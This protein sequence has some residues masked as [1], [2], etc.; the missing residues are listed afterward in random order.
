[1]PLTVVYAMQEPPSSWSQAIFLA[2][3][4]PRAPETPSWRPE[5]LRLLEEMGYRGVVF[6]P[7]TADG[8]W[9]QSYDDQVEWEEKCLHFADCIIFWVPRELKHM[10]ALTTN[11]EWGVWKDSG[12]VVFGAPPE[13][14]KVSYQKY[15]A[16]KLGVPIATTLHE[17][18][19]HAIF[20]T[21]TGDGALR[22]DGERHV[23]IQIWKTNHF[24]SWYRA[25]KEAG[26]RL[27]GARVVLT[28]RVGPGRKFV[29]FWAL[30][31]DV[32]IASEDRHK[33][34][35]VV[36]SRPDIATVCMYRQGSNLFDTDIVL[37]REFRS[38]ASTTDG[39]AHELPGGSSWKPGGDERMLAAEECHE[40]TGLRLPHWR[41]R[42]HDARQLVSTVSAHK[43]HLFSVA[44]TDEEL[45]FLRAQECVPHGVEGDTERTYVEIKK[46][47]EVMSG[48][49]VDWSVLGMIMSALEQPG[50]V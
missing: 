5:A 18:L 13:A 40:E 42:R 47:H 20:M 33:T 41:F 30:H 37:V 31:V 23:P 1:M 45:T 43:A 38:P 16:N 34:N 9:K 48:S 15:Y 22:R 50:G 21:M 26:N 12:K 17:T 8:T 39:F 24:Q 6:V 4:T 44:L 27:D 2:G 28:F 36:L 32:Y 10:P 14:V 25:Q 46:L 11:D 29:F 49:L 3:P 19:E 7:A 35:E